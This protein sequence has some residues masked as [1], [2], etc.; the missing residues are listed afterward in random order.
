MNESRFKLIKED[1]I[2]FFRLSPTPLDCLLHILPPR[3]LLVKFPVLVHSH[4]FSKEKEKKRRE[5]RQ[6]VNNSEEPF[7]PQIIIIIVRRK[8]SPLEP[9]PQPRKKKE[10]VPTSTFTTLKPRQV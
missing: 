8:T 9:Q 10:F 6:E 4:I 2:L 1:F 5:K 3:V 7:P